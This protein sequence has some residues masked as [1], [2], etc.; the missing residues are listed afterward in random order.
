MSQFR[1]DHVVRRL[2][3]RTDALASE[4]G[5]FLVETLVGAVLVAVLAVAMLSAFD[6][7][8]R[9]SGR[10]KMRALAASLAQSDQERLRS[11]P[12]ATLSNLR[13]TNSKMVDGVEYDVVS[14]AD[15]ISDPT[16]TTDCTNNGSA[17]DYMKITSTV[18]APSQPAMAPI[19]VESVVTPAPGTFSV[20]QGS[21]AVNVVDRNGNGISGLSVAINGPASASDV[22]DSRGCAFFGYEPIGSY[23]VSTTRGGWVDTQGNQTASKTVSIATQQMSTTT[24]QYDQAGSMTVTFD[25]VP[26]TRAAPRAP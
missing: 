16:S 18:T 14:R 7:A 9:V 19:V 25:T 20:N 11:M 8:D 26:P 17:G 15:W 6:G 21:L 24:L 1:V 2:R 13:Q 22:T 23:T 5:F 12:E 10:T 3:S 4:R